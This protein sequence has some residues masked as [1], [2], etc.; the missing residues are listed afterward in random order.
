MS[1]EDWEKGKGI[2]D[3]DDS[4][5]TT[6]KGDRSLHTHLKGNC[7]H[8]DG[9]HHSIRSSK[10]EILCPKCKGDLKPAL[11]CHVH[12]KSCCTKCEWGR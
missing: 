8:P 2:C 1:N 10:E 12:T 5:C 7:H 9:T 6:I 3:C 4:I 11:N